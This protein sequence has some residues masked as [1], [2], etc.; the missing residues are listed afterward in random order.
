MALE[1][2]YRLTQRIINKLPV[3][4]QSYLWGKSKAVD[5]NMKKHNEDD[6]NLSKSFRTE[7]GFRQ[8][9]ILCN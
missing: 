5:R 4:C 2:I 6:V 7:T 1:K 9:E 3:N 8:S